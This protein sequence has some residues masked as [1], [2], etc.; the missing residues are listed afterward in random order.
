[1]I[2]YFLIISMSPLRYLFPLEQK[3]LMFMTSIMIMF[4]IVMSLVGTKPKNERVNY[5]ATGEW[6]LAAKPTN[7]FIAKGKTLSLA[8]VG[9]GKV[10][11]GGKK[12]VGDEKTRANKNFSLTAIL[13]RPFRLRGCWSVFSINSH[14]KTWSKQSLFFLS[15]SQSS[16]NRDS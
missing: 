11:T 12:T 4:M 8:I 13:F 9:R 6:W 2:V 16:N 3:K 1:M 5:R 14:W 10:G 7:K 15:L